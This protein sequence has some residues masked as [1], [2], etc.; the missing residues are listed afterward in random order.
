M[1]RGSGYFSLP[2]S[3]SASPTVFRLHLCQLAPLHTTNTNSSPTAG[4]RTEFIG[5]RIFPRNAWFRWC[6]PP[7]EHPP[8]G[9]YCCLLLATFVYASLALQSLPR[10]HPPPRA[11]GTG[12]VAL[13]RE[14]WRGA[15][16]KSHST[17]WVYLGA[18]AA[19][20]TCGNLII[21]LE[22]G[23]SAIEL[24][25]RVLLRRPRCGR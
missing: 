1:S 20:G 13:A 3:Q 17:D 5:L 12:N 14:I 21:Y 23:P 19:E 7:L 11:G 8:L 4:L 9:L 2:I 10:T 24:S 15:S 6:F 18:N 25:S 16:A 22:A